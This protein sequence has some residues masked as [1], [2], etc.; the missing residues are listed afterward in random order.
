V[1]VRVC[2][3]CVLQVQIVEKHVVRVVTVVR[4]VLRAKGAPQSF[5]VHARQRMDDGRMRDRYLLPSEK[6]CRA[7]AGSRA[8]DL[9]AHDMSTTTLASLRSSAC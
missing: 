5:L 4:I 1:C 8:C 2:A 9:C 7:Y 6:V 3:S